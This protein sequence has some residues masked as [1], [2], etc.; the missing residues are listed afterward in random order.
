MSTILDTLFTGIASG[1]LTGL[2]GIVIQTWGKMQEQK[3]SLQMTRLNLANALEIQKIETAARE[4]MANISA[5]S[6]ERLATIDA[7]A[8]ASAQADENIRASYNHD[9]GTYLDPK[10]QM[11]RGFVGGFV[12]FLMGLVDFLR[13]LIRPGATIYTLLLHTGLIWWLYGLWQT[14]A[15][16]LTQDQTAALVAQIVGTTAYLVTTC[17]VW[18]FGVRPAQR[19]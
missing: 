13:G 2:G 8:R 17:T 6:A 18:W 1:G 9:K 19:R 5:E 4:R 3:F 12:T 11:R 16:T 10:A 7:E 14:K 15:L